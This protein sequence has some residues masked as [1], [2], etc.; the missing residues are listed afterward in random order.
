MI[1]VISR[2]LA[3]RTRAV[4]AVAVIAVAPT[5]ATAAPAAAHADRPLAWSACPAG[6]GVDP[7]QECATLAVPMDYAAPA[8]A[9]ISL[10]VSRI[11]TADPGRRRGVLVLI[12]GGPGS[13]GLNRPSAFAGKL[14]KEVLDRYDIIG[15]DP[16]GVGAS[17]PV[18]CQ[19]SHDDIAPVHFKPWPAA[20]G[21]ITD[22]I[23]RDRREAAACLANGGPLLSHITTRNEVRDL[24][25]IRQALGERKLSYWGVSYGTYVG[26]VY[27]TQYPQRTDRVVLD[28]NDDPDPTRVARGWLANYAIG[29]EDRFPDFAAWYAPD[30]PST[31]RQTFLDL[32]ARLDRQPLP[33]PGANPSV[34]DGNVLRDTLLN[35][36]YSDANFPQ[37]ASLMNAALHGGPLPAPSTPP[38]AQLQNN[39]AVALA[40]IC[41]DVAWPRSIEQY[42]R[43][44][45]VDRVNY[46]LT[47][48]MPVNIG[49]CAFWPAP[50]EQPVRV[51][52]HGPAN[53][54]L[55]QNRR[56]PATPLR[57]AR[58][59]AAALG[60]RATMIVV[61]AGGHGSYLANGNAQGDAAVTAFLA[62]GQRP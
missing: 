22:N 46:P 36:L 14:P 54:L 53:V 33:W 24:D 19:L 3:R 18:S 43:E 48:G 37:L 25:A 40:T 10:A 57:G 23:A 47:V 6:P 16:R 32:A 41:N 38:E 28:S 42:E 29:V 39:A 58:R 5:P 50:A 59:M 11:R 21:S 9:R 45:A 17:T 56:D 35:A 60:H 2:F 52:S 15:F 7:R 4:A 61:D 49:P 26:A 31:V 20:D 34:L 51:G 27:A 12:P 44:V 13:P 62:Y 55:I 30:D 8:G 1:M